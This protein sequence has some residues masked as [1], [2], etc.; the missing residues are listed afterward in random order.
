[1]SFDFSISDIEALAK[2]LTPPAETEVRFSAE[3]SSRSEPELLVAYSHA[4]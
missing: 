2:L 1:M 4:R 3:C